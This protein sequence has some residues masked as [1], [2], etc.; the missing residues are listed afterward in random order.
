M[1][2]VAGEIIA[3]RKLC[4]QPDDLYRQRDSWEVAGDFF[5]GEQP[6]L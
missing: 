5:S 2:T 3:E 6:W 4:D 1:E